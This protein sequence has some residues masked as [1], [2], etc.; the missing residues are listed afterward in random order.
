MTEEQVK[1]RRLYSQGK[2]IKEINK[3]TKIP[4]RTL[5][6]WKADVEQGWEKARRLAQL[7]PEA[8]GDLLLESYKEAVLDIA[9]NPI[10]LQNPSVADSLIKVVKAIKSFQKDVDYLG[11]GTDVIKKITILIK[12][13]FPEHIGTWKKLTP[14]IFEILEEE[15]GR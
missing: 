7:S 3:L 1:A 4:S 14:R 5:Y 10:K 13:E 12:D 15:Y 11:V 2:E 9:D 6:A 8:L